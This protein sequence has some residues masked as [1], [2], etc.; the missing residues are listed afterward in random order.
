MLCRSNK[1]ELEHKSGGSG[2]AV[3]IDEGKSGS[4][5]SMKELFQEFHRLKAEKRDSQGPTVDDVLLD[6]SDTSADSMRKSV[7]HAM[8]LEG[9]LKKSGESLARSSFLLQRHAF[10]YTSLLKTGR[11]KK[12]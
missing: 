8:G 5:A 1:Q 9:F 6:V 2:N 4:D 7:M 3:T 10:M 12:E 11:K